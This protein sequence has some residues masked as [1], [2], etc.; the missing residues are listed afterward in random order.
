MYQT[1]LLTADYCSSRLVRCA[2]RVW[3]N[4]P[5]LQSSNAKCLHSGRLH[6]HG[7][8]WLT[9]P[10]L[11]LK[12]PFLRAKKRCGNSVVG[13]PQRFHNASR[14][15]QQAPHRCGLPHR[16]GDPWVPQ[17][18][19]RRCGSV[20][21]VCERVVEHATAFLPLLSALWATVVAE[22]EINGLTT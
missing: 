15:C 8:A 2:R 13:L 7:C 18:V 20:V 21:G 5:R 4:M 12:P 19:P 16:C 1:P 3:H 9:A 14:F 22:F 6:L 17:E 10:A 11:L